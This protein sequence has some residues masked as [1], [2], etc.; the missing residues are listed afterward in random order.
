[1]H[2]DQLRSLRSLLATQPEL[3][4]RVSVEV[5]ECCSKRPIFPQQP[6]D[7]TRPNNTIN[8]NTTQK[9]AYDGD[10][11]FADREAI[12]ERAHIL[13]SNPDMLHQS[14]CPQHRQWGGF[15]SALR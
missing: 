3:A 1:M 15:L 2:Q 9:K 12:R 10:T 4:A 8:T 14:V 6:I 13:L 11:P 5:S 7:Q